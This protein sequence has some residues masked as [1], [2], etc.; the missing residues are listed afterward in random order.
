[1][2]RKSVILL[3]TRYRQILFSSLLALSLLF[4]LP[5]NAAA[6]TSTW[7]FDPNHTLV[8]FTVRHLMI[9]NVHGG[10]KKLSGSV[11]YDPK[12]LS[13]TAVQV[14]IETASLDSG[15]EGRDKDLKS[16]RFLDIEK[17]PTITYQ[18]KRAEPAGPGKLK[19]TGDL[20]IHGVTKEVIL[21]VEGP[22]DPVKVGPAMHMGAAASTKINRKEFGLLYNAALE[23]GGMV[24]GD[25]VLINLDIDMV[26]QAP[27]SPGRGPGG[28]AN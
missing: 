13:K 19:V 12:D 8:Q 23:T 28:T 15:S 17:Y 26:Q 27:A 25:D 14:T 6:Q 22:T 7:T 4:L 16:A 21:D 11:Q 9:T 10:F 20:T 5:G 18:S 3:E 24:V 1:M 2:G